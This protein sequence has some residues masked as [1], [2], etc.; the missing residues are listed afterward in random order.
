MTRKLF[1]ITN[2]SVIFSC[3]VG[4]VCITNATVILGCLVYLVCYHQCHRHT[5][6][7]GLSCLSS[8]KFTFIL[9]AWFI[10]F[11]INQVHLHIWLFGLSCLL[12]TNFTIIFG[13]S[14]YFQQGWTHQ[15]R[16]IWNNVGLLCCP[17]LLEVVVASDSGKYQQPTVVGTI[18][19]ILV[20][21]MLPTNYFNSSAVASYTVIRSDHNKS[22][23]CPRQSLVFRS[24]LIVEWETSQST[25]SRLR[26]HIKAIVP[27]QDYSATND[28][29]KTH[30]K[31]FQWKKIAI[32]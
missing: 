30:Q 10:L 6:S 4:L 12:S 29:S 1:H 14:Q 28:Q 9:V 23:M 16:Y 25:I 18:L 26:C 21:T 13:C 8:T 20:N 11:V 19:V 27:Y 17:V 24:T 15:C 7:L 22:N 31:L 3:L 5:W 2:S 32:P